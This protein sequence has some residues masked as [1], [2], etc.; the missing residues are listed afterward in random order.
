MNARKSPE[1][2]AALTAEADRIIAAVTH[3]SSATLTQIYDAGASIKTP[4]VRT[5]PDENGGMTA[6]T[7]VLEIAHPFV[8]SALDVYTLREALHPMRVTRYDERILRLE[9]MR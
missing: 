7:L 9:R 6:T 8:L 4:L 5:L 2:T 1:R 3:A